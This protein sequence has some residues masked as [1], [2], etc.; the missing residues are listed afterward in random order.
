MDIPDKYIK[1]ISVK[2]EINP[3]AVKV[4][5]EVNS[6]FHIKLGDKQGCVL[7]PFIWI[8]RMDFVLRS[9][10]K[11]AEEYGIKLEGKLC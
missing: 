7:S 3:A 8:I 11:V 1:V 6:W 9:I 10:G 5:N 2:S 4:G